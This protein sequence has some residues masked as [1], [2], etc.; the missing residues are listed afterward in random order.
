MAHGFDGT[1]FVRGCCTNVR[2]R[3]QQHADAEHLR[4][5]RQ[6]FVAA[7]HRAHHT[8]AGGTRHSGLERVGQLMRQQATH[9]VVLAL[10]H[11]GTDLRGRNQAARRIVHQHPVLRGCATLQQHFQPTH[12]RIRTCRTAAGRVPPGSAAIVIEELIIRRHRHQR[13]C[14]PGNGGKRSQRVQHHGLA[15]HTLVLFGYLRGGCSGRNGACAHT[16]TGNQAPE[17]HLW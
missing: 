4:R 3:I 17:S 1:G 5:L 9:A 12:H 11:Q 7:I 2:Q 6:P 8:H 16:G 15:S 13:T 14:Q 10:L